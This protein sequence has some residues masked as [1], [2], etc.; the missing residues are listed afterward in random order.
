MIADAEVPAT[1][2]VQALELVLSPERA[3]QVA[4][5]AIRP[6]R[7]EWRGCP[8]ELNSWIALQKHLHHHCQQVEASSSQAPFH[9][10]CERCAV[11]L[12][13]SLSSLLQHITFSHMSRVPLPCPVEGCSEAFTYKQAPTAIPAHLRTDHRFGGSFPTRLPPLRQSRT[14]KKPP[15]RALPPLPHDPV[16]LYTLLL[17]PVREKPRRAGSTA[18]QT[19]RRGRWKRMSSRAAPPSEASDTDEPES[20]PFADLDPQASTSYYS[21]PQNE[22]LEW[23]AYKAPPEPALQISRPQPMIIPPVREKPP[24]PSIGYVAFAEKFAQLELAGIID[25]TG[26][27]PQDDSERDVE[28]DARDARTP[29]KGK[30]KDKDKMDTDSPD[31]A[32]GPSRARQGGEGG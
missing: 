30:G 2:Q 21:S 20:M 15:R 11:R 28:A 6:T 32:A 16:P 1:S 22:C 14:P 13:D 8:A 5:E 23:V 17:P 31:R 19:A 18:S 29:G 27:W 7:C 9:C 12:H 10:Q 26:Q 25:G 24:A 3:V 4:S